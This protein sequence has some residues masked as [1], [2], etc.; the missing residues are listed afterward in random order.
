VTAADSP[1]LDRKYREL[2]PAL[3]KHL[4]FSHAA[5]AEDIAA[6]VWAEVAAAL[7]RFSGDDRDFRAWVFTLARRR[8]ID[9]YRR[10]GR[11]PVEPLGDEESTYHVEPGIE[12]DAVERLT[13]LAAISAVQ[14]VL[15]RHQ[16]E[17]VLLRVVGGLGV[18]R[19]AGITGLQ[20]VNVRVI[21]HRALRR[22]AEQLTTADLRSA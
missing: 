3:L 14:D 7:P 12:D 20:P 15:P 18:K 19:V 11:R 22:L 16:A 10:L 17:V 5:L 9:S 21:Q 4:R 13:T 1:D 8:V 6:D 2:Q